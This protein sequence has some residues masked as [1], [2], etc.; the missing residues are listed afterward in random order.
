MK[1]ISLSILLGLSLTACGGGGGG[2]TGGG[3]AATPAPDDSQTATPSV[4]TKDLVAP[5]GFDYDPIENRNVAIDISSTSIA[6]AYLSIYRN[7]H[8]LSDGTLLPDYGSRIVAMPLKDGKADLSVIISDSSNDLL[9][10]I[11]F[12]DGSAP[13]QTRFYASQSTWSW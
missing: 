11:W 4:K 3:S 1:N 7:Y 5:E 9:G 8:T 10:E 6:R 13:L 2:S 12:Y